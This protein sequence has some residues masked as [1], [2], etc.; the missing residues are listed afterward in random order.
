MPRGG[1]RKNAG[2]PIGSK[3]R[4]RVPLKTRVDIASRVLDEVDAV[5]LWKELLRDKHSRIRF[6]ALEY[7]TD[8]VYGKPIQ[9]IQG[10]LNPVEINLTWA[11]SPAPQWAMRNVTPD[12]AKQ[13]LTE[14]VESQA[15][16][17]S[18]TPQWVEPD[19]KREY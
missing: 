6:A 17:N 4:P 1:A 16:E 7:L 3:N 8:R 9:Q 2:R 19:P 12:P 10:G 14:F 13:L 11:G 18:S 5:A 15:S